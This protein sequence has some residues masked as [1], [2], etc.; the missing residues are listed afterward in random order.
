MSSS[1]PYEYDHNGRRVI[2]RKT[3]NLEDLNISEVS[4]EEDN[5]ESQQEYLRKIMSKP[6][7]PLKKPKPAPQ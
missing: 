7:N 2:T 4:H 6:R 5:Y 1:S 3:G